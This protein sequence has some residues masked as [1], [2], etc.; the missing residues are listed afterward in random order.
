MFLHFGKDCCYIRRYLFDTVF[1]WTR[2][3]IG[4]YSSWH[5]H[6]MFLHCDTDC[7]YIRWYLFGTVLQ[8]TQEHIDMYSSWH[9]QSMFLH[10]DT[11]CCYIRWYLFG[12]VFQWTQE[13]IGMYSSW[14]YPSMFLHFDKDCCYIRCY[15]FD[16]IFPWTRAHTDT[17]SCWHCRSRLLHFDTDC[18]YTRPYLFRIVIL[19]TR[20]HNDRCSGWHSQSMFL[21]FDKDCCHIR[22]Y[23]FD[24]LLLR[25]QAHIHTCSGWHSY[26]KHLHFHKDCWH[27]RWYLFDIVF[28][29]IQTHIDTYSGRH[30][31]C[32]FLR[33]DTDCCR[34]CSQS[35][36]AVFLPYIHSYGCGSNQHMFHHF[37]KDCWQILSYF[38][39]RWNDKARAYNFSNFAIF[40]SGYQQPGKNGRE[41][42]MFQSSC[43]ELIFPNRSI[44]IRICSIQSNI[45]F[46]HLFVPQSELRFP[47]YFGTSPAFHCFSHTRC[48]LQTSWQTRN[49]GRC[50]KY[51]WQQS[52]CYG[53][54]HPCI[55]KLPC[56]HKRSH[57]YTRCLAGSPGNFLRRKIFFPHVTY[58]RACLCY[59]YSMDMMLYLWSSLRIS[60]STQ[61]VLRREHSEWGHLYSIRVHPRTSTW[62]S[63]YVHLLFPPMCFLDV[64]TMTAQRTKMLEL[65]E[66]WIPSFHTFDWKDQRLTE[67]TMRRERKQKK[68]QL[69]SNSYFW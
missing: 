63:K 36:Y 41:E 34:I 40:L 35:S 48:T 27:I 47:S 49:G 67:G 18:C 7:C 1:P 69:I 68:T 11:D 66:K 42:G 21:H 14:H 60:T 5:C 52:H 28:P 55:L 26:S 51:H 25:T 53:N 16:T 62:D 13:H 20:A 6:S 4:T 9:C 64:Y 2:A 37:D 45:S 56:V 10:C 15:L 57:V 44:S 19:W 43:K 46:P 39:C 61:E 33:F 3:H 17:Y 24:I 32:M 38:W 50:S 22:W 58:V 31:H 30:C 8:W 65:L 23:L 54:F 59:K 12:T 29:R